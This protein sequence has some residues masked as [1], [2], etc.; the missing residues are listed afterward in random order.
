MLHSSLRKLF[1][2]LKTIIPPSSIESE[3]TVCVTMQFRI[4]IYQCPGLFKAYLS[5]RGTRRKRKIGERI[6]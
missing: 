1:E 3:R 2:T 5:K 4:S 6:E